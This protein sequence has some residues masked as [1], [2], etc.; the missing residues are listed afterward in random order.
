MSNP[1][2]RSSLDCDEEVSMTRAPAIRASCAPYSDTPPVPRQ[3]TVS[4][5]WSVGWWPNRDDQEV[6]AQP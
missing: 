1:T 3:R 5:D 6:V 2:A 4:P